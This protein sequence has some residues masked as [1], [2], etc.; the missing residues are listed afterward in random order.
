MKDMNGLS[1]KL[2]KR[3]LLEIKARNL[4]LNSQSISSNSDIWL[5]EKFISK[6]SELTKENLT[7]MLP[8]LD[9]DFLLKLIDILEEEKA[10]LKALEFEAINMM[11]RKK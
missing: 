1:S 6:E 2:N 9:E 4:I 5:S 8:N 11:R 10:K 3:K 7:K